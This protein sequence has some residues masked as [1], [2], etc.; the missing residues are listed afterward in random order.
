MQIGATIRTRLDAELDLKEFFAEPTVA[1]TAAL[2]EAGG[3]GGAKPEDTIRA[4][5]R[6]EPEDGPDLDPDGLDGLSDEEVEAML[7]QV[8]AEEAAGPGTRGS[9]YDRSEKGDRA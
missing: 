4:L 3:R 5:R 7:Q 8:L 6:D 2:L 9:T 1:R